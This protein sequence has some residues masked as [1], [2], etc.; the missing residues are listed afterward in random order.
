MPLPSKA[1]SPRPP[2]AEDTTETESVRFLKNRLE[3][4]RY[5]LAST[6]FVLGILIVLDLIRWVAFAIHHL[7]G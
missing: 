5:Q 7:A 1:T 3:E 4:T 2:G 6:R